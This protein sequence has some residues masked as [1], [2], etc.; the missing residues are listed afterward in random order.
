M[1]DKNTPLK[2][3]FD[4]PMEQSAVTASSIKVEDDNGLVD[5]S[6]HSVDTADQTFTFTP[7][8]ELK[9]DVSITLG[10]AIKDADGDALAETQWHFRVPYWEIIG[11]DLSVDRP[12]GLEVTVAP[13]GTPYLAIKQ[14]A[15]TGA[16]SEA[17]IQRYN[18]NQG[19]WEKVGNLPG[20][21]SLVGLQVG[22]DG[23]PRV[24]RIKSTATRPLEVFQFDSNGN[25]W[26][27]LG[28]ANDE[29]ET[30]MVI[31]RFFALDSNDVPYVAHVSDKTGT[32]NERRVRVSKYN[33]GTDSWEVLGGNTGNQYASAG[34]VNFLV[35]AISPNDIPYV[36]FR[37][38]DESN[39]ALTVMK[40]T[41]NDWDLVGARGFSGDTAGSIDLA[42]DQNNVPY[43]A[44]S[45]HQASRKA[46]VAKFNGTS[47]EFLGDRGFSISPDRGSDIF[48][49]IQLVLDSN[50]TPIIAAQNFGGD[51][52]LVVRTFNGADWV[53][54]AGVSHIDEQA[55][56]I[57]MA[58]GPDNELYVTYADKD[59]DKTKAQVFR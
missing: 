50:N 7:D 38:E 5:V 46:S 34:E 4:T 36:A 8:H 55:Q 19:D 29:T 42:F 14:R 16:A 23:I 44:F 11:D 40:F 26:T 51:Y 48:L 25:N 37:D 59:T 22:S 12:A 41:G 47:W 32:A 27:S 3:T 56:N 21:P 30:T 24:A 43:V 1:V 15:A 52:K 6:F 17:L 2:I 49:S 39:D 31:T 54:F 33:A 53:N 58:I 20:Q 13:D 45:D 18:S 10:T 35:F 28:E 57:S 9:G